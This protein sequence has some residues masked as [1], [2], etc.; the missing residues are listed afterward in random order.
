MVP[1]TGFEPVVFAVRGRCPKPLDEC[2]MKNHIYITY[3]LIYFQPKNKLKK[4]YFN[5]LYAINIDDI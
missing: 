3:N 5:N 1:H 2:G 4:L